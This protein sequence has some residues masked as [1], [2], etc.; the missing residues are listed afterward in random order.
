MTLINVATEEYDK[1]L[2]KQNSFLLEK[3]KGSNFDEASYVSGMTHTYDSSIGRP[4]LSTSEKNM[5]NK[6]L[7]TEKN[8]FQRSIADLKAQYDLTTQHRQS[9]EEKL[10][11]LEADRLKFLTYSYMILF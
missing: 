9:L 6:Q 4:F 3:M 1:F 2:E 5:L 7:E 11:L 8:N 10:Y